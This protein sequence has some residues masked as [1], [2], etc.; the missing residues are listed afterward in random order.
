MLNEKIQFI[1]FKN[2]VLGWVPTEADANSRSVAYLVTVGHTGKGE[3]KRDIG[4]AANES[5]IVMKVTTDENQ[6]NLTGSPEPR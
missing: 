3:R 2:Y 5:C 4:K 6:L 1:N